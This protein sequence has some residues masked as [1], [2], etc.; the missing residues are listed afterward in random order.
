MRLADQNPGKVLGVAL[1]LLAWVMVPAGPARAASQDQALFYDALAPYGAWVNYSQY[2]PV[3][4]PTRGVP[5][6]WRPYVD[7]R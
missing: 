3:W 6:N 4:Y 5:A 1:L 7:G 2:G